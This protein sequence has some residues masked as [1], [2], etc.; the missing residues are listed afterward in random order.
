[1]ALDNANPTILNTSELFSQRERRRNQK[2]AVT[3]TDLRDLIS[4]HALNP[5][6]TSE[7]SDSDS[8][9]S[10]PDAIDEEEIYGE[11][12][13]Y[14]KISQEA[15]RVTRFRGC[16]PRLVICTVPG[17]LFLAANLN[18]NFICFQ[19][20]HGKHF[21]LFGYPHVN[22]VWRSEVANIY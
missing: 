18:L 15:T 8:E 17:V 19:M 11:F 10:T 5:L 4:S 16:Q 3:K 22:M 13:Q 21:T 14:P 20:R 12:M 7:V 2:A 9:D 6:Y 1:M